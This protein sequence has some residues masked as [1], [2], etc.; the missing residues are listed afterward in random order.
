[1]GFSCFIEFSSFSVLSFDTRTH[2]KVQIKKA[3]FSEIR[4]ITQTLPRETGRRPGRAA[5]STGR[6]PS[7]GVMRALRIGGS[8]D[9]QL[10]RLYQMREPRRRPCGSSAK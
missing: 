5:P 3:S 8:G 1:L 7:G 9:C 10:Q 4:Q 2:G 6:D